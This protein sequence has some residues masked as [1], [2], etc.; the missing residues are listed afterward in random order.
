MI[1]FYQRHQTKRVVPLKLC[2]ALYGERTSTLQSY[3]EPDLSAGVSIKFGDVTSQYPNAQL[4]R[5]FVVGHPNILLNG[6]SAMPKIED[7]NGV[8]KAKVL[9][10]THLFVPVLPYRSCSN[11]LFIPLSYVL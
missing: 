6:D 2:D 7:M 5:Q 11:L 3:V 8:V 9:P 1:A 10:Q 4:H